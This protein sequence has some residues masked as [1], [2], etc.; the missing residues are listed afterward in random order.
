MNVQD[1]NITKVSRKIGFVST[2]FSI[3]NGTDVFFPMIDT[4]GDMIVE[5]EP[6]LF[7]TTCCCVTS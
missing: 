2:P 4:L 6:T 5:E 3:I 7:P 1:I